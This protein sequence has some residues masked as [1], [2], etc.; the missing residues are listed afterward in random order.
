VEKWADLPLDVRDI[1]ERIDSAPDTA[2]DIY[3]DGR[4]AE[5]A[6]EVKLSLRMITAELA[7][8]IE[9]GKSTPNFLYHLYG[10]ADRT[11]DTSLLA[12]QAKYADNYVRSAISSRH[13]AGEAI[14]ALI[15]WMYATHLLYTGIDTCQKLTLADEPE[16]FKLGGGGMDEFIALWIGNGG[17]SG[18]GRNSLYTLTQYVASLFGTTHPEAAA[19]RELKALYQEGSA[20]LSF[21]NACTKDDDRAV[22]QLWAVAQRMISQMTVPLMQLLIDALFQEDPERVKLYALAVIPQTVQCRPSTYKRLKEELL[23]TTVVF[24]RK[25]EI[26]VDLQD[27]YSCLGFSCGDIGSYMQDQIPACTDKPASFPIAEYVP[28]SHVQSVRYKAMNWFCYNKLR[29]NAVHS[30]SS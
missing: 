24:S 4:N 16:A 18:V 7:D 17:G 9:A 25:A 27:V 15:I 2:L 5:S 12:N 1:Q 22:P 19:N 20:I 3:E 10:L 30:S 23:G 29:A 13:E 8:T 26:L 6:P 21:Q 14:L 28:T 11:T